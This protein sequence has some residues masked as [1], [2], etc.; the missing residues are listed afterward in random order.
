M[1]TRTEAIAIATVTSVRI[2]CNAQIARAPLGS[3]LP[4][5]ATDRSNYRACEPLLDTDPG[6]AQIRVPCPVN[7]ICCGADVRV[8]WDGVGQE[9]G[10]GRR[11]LGFWYN[12]EVDAIRHAIRDALQS[13]GV[14]MWGG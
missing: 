13:S 3:I 9:R 10:G 7:E 14:Q 6:M 2:Q 1:A 4:A 8:G 5:I 11:E 12:G